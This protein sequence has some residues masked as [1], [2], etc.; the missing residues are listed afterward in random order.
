MLALTYQ[1]RN[2]LAPSYLA[3]LLND[4]VPGRAL[5]SSDTLTLAVPL[6]KLKTVADRSFSSAGHRACNSLRHSLRAGALACPD[7]TPDTAS[8]LLCCYLSD[9]QFGGRSSDTSSVPTCSLARK[10]SDSILSAPTGSAHAML[11]ISNIVLAEYPP[12]LT[13]TIDT[14]HCI[15]MA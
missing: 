2:G 5:R 15:T 7:A 3:E 12:L 14:L 4:F 10:Q 11:D 9:T 8:A 1:V 6:F 13:A